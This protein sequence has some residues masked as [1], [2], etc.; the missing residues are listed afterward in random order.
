[1]LNKIYEIIC[2][3]C[4]KY[5][6][7]EVHMCSNNHVTCRKCRQLLSNCL[8]C[9]VRYI[10]NIRNARLENLVKTHLI[11]CKYR[12][13]SCG[14]RLSVIAIKE[15]EDDCEFAAYKC[16]V[17]YMDCPFHGSI[18]EIEVHLS[19]DH[20]IPIERNIASAYITEEQTS[21]R[22]SFLERIFHFESNKFYLILEKCKSSFG[23][24]I[25]TVSLQ[26]IGPKKVA[27]KLSSRSTMSYNNKTRTVT[28]NIQSIRD[29]YRH[30]NGHLI[31]QSS[32][33]E[34]VEEVDGFEMIQIFKLGTSVYE[35]PSY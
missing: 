27:S 24:L 30:P 15:H 4:N 32:E 16:P 1:M 26:L 2:V 12:A 5:A 3:N 18:N 31:F 11:P 7:P 10:C 6:V 22:S 14:V 25:F 23:T 35:T 19:Y 28:S 9:G 29:S 13:F 17:P 20:K 33:I 8:F 21:S 34:D